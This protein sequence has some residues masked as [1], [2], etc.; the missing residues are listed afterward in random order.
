MLIFRALTYVLP[1][2]LGLAAYVLWRR[3][4]SW[5]RVPNTAPRTAL[6]PESV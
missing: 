4:R 3:N 2:P 5:R 1:I 6:V